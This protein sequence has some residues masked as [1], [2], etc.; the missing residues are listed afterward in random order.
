MELPE[1]SLLN[2]KYTIPLNLQTSCLMLLPLSIYIVRFNN[3][4]SFLLRYLAG[5]PQLG[6]PVAIPS[7]ILTI[8]LML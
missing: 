6:N 1:I 2:A 5:L 8:P 7:D 3:I 4:Q